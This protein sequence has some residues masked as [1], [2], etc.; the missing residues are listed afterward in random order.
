MGNIFTRYAIHK[1][2]L[3]EK[4]ESTLGGQSIW[5]DDAVRRLNTDGHGRLLGEFGNGD[6][7]LAVTRQGKF[8][9]TDYDLSNRYEEE[10]LLVEKFDPEKIFSATYYDAEQKYSYV[11]RFTFEESPNIQLFIDEA[12]G[13]YL[14]EL[15]SDDYPQ[16]QVTFKGK[17]AKREPEQVDVDEF[18]GIKSFRAK[19]KRVSTLDIGT[20]KFIEPLVKELPQSNDNDLL[21]SDDDGNA[22]QMSL[23]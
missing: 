19:G 10:M 2:V 3:K 16:L 18:I 23:L 6:K 7:V 4:G 5:F 17:N 20:L 22:V 8:Y 11:K 1:V 21:Q 13:S 12:E 14:V 15:S 9:T